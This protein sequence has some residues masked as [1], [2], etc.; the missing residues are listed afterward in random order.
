MAFLQTG[1]QDREY[2]FAEVSFNIFFI[3]SNV[4]FFGSNLFFRS[5]SK[6]NGHGI[7]YFLKYFLVFE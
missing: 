6:L 3:F 5:V 4:V 2:S 7:L 1:P